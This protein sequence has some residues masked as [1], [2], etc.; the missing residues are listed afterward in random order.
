MQQN[1]Q[2]SVQSPRVSETCAQCPRWSSR[3]ERAAQQIS[4]QGSRSKQQQDFSAM[5]VASELARELLSET[6]W[7][8][9]E[10]PS[11]RASGESGQG[12][13]G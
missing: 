2:V 13:N 1:P 5:D 11:M 6:G 7:A 12:D 4:M 10:Q 3:K 9:F 8:M